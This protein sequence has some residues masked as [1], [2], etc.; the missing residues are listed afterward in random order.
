MLPPTSRGKASHVQ[1]NPRWRRCARVNYWRRWIGAWRK[2]TVGLTLTERGAYSE[3]LD[4]YYAN[5][6]ALPMDREQCYRM[7]GAFTRE[8]R[9]A[10][11][12]I[13]RNPALFHENGGQ[14][15]NTR[16]DE[17]IAQAKK[18]GEVQRQRRLGKTKDRA[19]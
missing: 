18:Y 17:E 8:E 11:D 19:Q 5:D 9:K 10:V 1:A 16:A 3:L 6:G 12:R 14:L 2:K 13:L 4:A 15:H 7:A